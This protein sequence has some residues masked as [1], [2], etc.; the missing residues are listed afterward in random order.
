MGGVI[1]G[2]LAQNDIIM[3]FKILFLVMMVIGVASCKSVDAPMDVTVG[4]KV[5]ATVNVTIPEDSRA[6]SGE[7]FDLSTLEQE[8]SEYEMRFILEVYYGNERS[9]RQVKYVSVPTAAF[10]IRLVP[11]RDYRLAVWADIVAKVDNRDVADDYDRY[12]ET[13]SSLKS[14]SI[15]ES[16]WR[17]DA[18]D[19]DAYTGNADIKNFSSASP[20]NV[21]L[22]RPFAMLRVV[23]TD[24]SSVVGNV[25]KLSVTYNDV[26]TAFNACSGEVVENSNKEHEKFVIS[27]EYNDVEGETTLFTD[28]IFAPES[29]TPLNFSFSAYD[30]E[31][32]LIKQNNFGSGVTI[33]RNTLTTIKGALFSQN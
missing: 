9:S 22:K 24:Y 27:S 11:E 32:N 8:D 31:D 13:S 25:N 19:C 10:D 33:K 14:V 2:A 12:Y 30:G 28:Y 23:A 7:G 1:N 4:E 5:A 17:C 29:D 3:R 21:L 20:I 15:I 26:Y 6:A 18:L 16:E